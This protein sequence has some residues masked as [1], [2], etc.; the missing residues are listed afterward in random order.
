MRYP[1]TM[2]EDYYDAK[3]ATEKTLEELHQVALRIDGKVEEILDELKE[4]VTYQSESSY[5]G[6]S[7]NDFY[8]D[9]E[10]E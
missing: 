8:R 4:L 7:M 5:H 3:R 9:H 2:T 1:F 6:Y 10:L